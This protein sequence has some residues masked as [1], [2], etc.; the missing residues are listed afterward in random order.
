MN[1]RIL[2]IIVL[3]LVGLVGLGMSLCGG[4]FTLA[5]LADLGH[6]AG[7]PGEFG[8]AGFLIMSVPSLLVGLGLVWLAAR[9]INKQT[10]NRADKTPR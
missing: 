10:G 9:G 2:V 8:M 6:H 1:V 7:H 4:F 3:G 5:G